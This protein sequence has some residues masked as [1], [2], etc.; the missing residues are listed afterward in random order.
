M[1]YAI[2]KATNDDTNWLDDLRRQ[3]YLNLFIETWGAWDEDRHTRHFAGFLQQGSISIIEVDLKSA[4]MIQVFETESEIELSEIQILPSH[5][6]KGLGTAI[7]KDLVQKASSAN[8][9]ILLSLGLKNTGAFALYSR[10]GFIEYDRSESH[11]YM[12]MDS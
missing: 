10:L 12:K 1:H 7:I 8:K 11:I 5:Q 9:R 2:R 4:G 6:S 3:A